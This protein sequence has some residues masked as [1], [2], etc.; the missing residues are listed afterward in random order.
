MRSPNLLLTLASLLALTACHPADVQTSPGTSNG[1]TGTSNSGGAPGTSTS[2]AGVATPNGAPAPT[3][4]ADPNAASPAAGGA[5][6]PYGTA[7]STA[8]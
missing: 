2:P 8:P 7:S 4:P 6:L 5:S 3:M 1:T